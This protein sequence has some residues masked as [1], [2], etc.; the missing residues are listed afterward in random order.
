MRRIVAL[1]VC[2]FLSV[3]F[4]YAQESETRNL[5]SFS[6]IR[7]GEAIDVYLKKGTKES[8]RVIASGVRLSDVLTEVKGSNLVIEMRDGNYR[9]RNVKVYVTYV[10][11]E[12]ISCS[13]AA[14]LYSED[15]IKASDLTLSVSSSGNIEL[16]IEASKTTASA[17]SA[18]D[19]ILE[20]KTGYLNADASSAGEI[21]AYNLEADRVDAEASSAGDI[22]VNAKNEIE[23]RASSGGSIRYRGNP[24]KTNTNSSSGGS[25]R[26]SS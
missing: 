25:V 10:S 22:R 19:M 6:G 4:I 13:S 15:V 9:S 17:S 14:N 11:L 7:A 20:G 23:A 18:G 1:S 3:T 2:I 21:D 16:K 26:K 12:K 5:S 8:A 24:S